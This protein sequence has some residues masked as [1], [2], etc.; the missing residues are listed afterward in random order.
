MQWTEPNTRSIG[1]AASTSAASSG[2]LCGSPSSTPLRTRRPGKSDRQRSSSRQYAQTS[3]RWKLPCPPPVKSACS[4]NAMAG[5]PISTARRQVASMSPR[6]AS[7]ENCVC[8]WKSAVGTILKAYLP[9]EARLQQA[10]CHPGVGA[11]ARGP[12][13][14][15]HQRPDRLLLSRA[16]VGGGL[17]VLRDDPVH[18]RRQLRLVADLRQPAVP[19]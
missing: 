1:P 4:V 15:A 13:D 14:L 11:A 2:N 16:V 3:S 19:H 8:T 18:D 17:R 5:R 10:S 6:G 12:P 7:Q 9:L